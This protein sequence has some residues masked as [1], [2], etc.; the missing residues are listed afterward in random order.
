MGELTRL[1][2]L[3]KTQPSLTTYGDAARFSSELHLGE[4][5]LGFPHYIG[6]HERLDA[7]L[8][9]FPCDCHDVSYMNI[10]EQRFFALRVEKF[11]R[12][13]RFH[14]PGKFRR[15]P[16][17]TDHD[18]TARDG[19]YAG[20]AQKRETVI[21]DM[22]FAYGVR[23]RSRTRSGGCGEVDGGCG[24]YGPGTVAQGL[25]ERRIPLEEQKPARDGHRRGNGGNDKNPLRKY[26]LPKHG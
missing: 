23:H 16:R 26:F 15:S 13:A 25:R 5:S 8:G 18:R 20:A 24:S 12:V 2:L 14:G 11:C 21:G 19:K 17:H 1:S 3:M 7:P 4:N 10:R 22:H 9:N 6:A